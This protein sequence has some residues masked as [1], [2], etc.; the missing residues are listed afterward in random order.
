MARVQV[1]TVGGAYEVCTLC[2]DHFKMEVLSQGIEI[3]IGTISEVT[4]EDQS[5]LGCQ[6]VGVWIDYQAPGGCSS[7]LLFRCSGSE[8]VDKV[9]RLVQAVKLAHKSLNASD[10]ALQHRFQGA[11]VLSNGA[12]VYKHRPKQ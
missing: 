7:S 6:A 10:H 8:S 5:T 11:R 3:P 4:Y 2:I 9:H 1:F 12:I